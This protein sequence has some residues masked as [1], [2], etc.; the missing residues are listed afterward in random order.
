[1]ANKQQQQIQKVLSLY[2]DALSR[3]YCVPPVQF[4][5]VAYERKTVAGQSVLVLQSVPN[6]A[7]FSQSAST[8]PEEGWGSDHDEDISLTQ[9]VCGSSMHS[10]SGSR[11][12][13]LLSLDGTPAQRP[14]FD[15]APAERPVF[16]GTPAERPL[17][18]GTP[19]ERPH[20]DG[21]PAERPLFD[22]TPAERPLFDGTPAE[23]PLFDGT[24]AERPL[25]D[26]TP[27]ERPLFD[28]TPAERPSCGKEESR[29]GH[30][31]PGNTPSADPEA[32]PPSQRDRR[33]G[34]ADET[35]TSATASAT[36]FSR[37]ACGDQSACTCPGQTSPPSSDLSKGSCSAQ[38]DILC[39]SHPSQ[40]PSNKAFCVHAVLDNPQSRQE[41][42]CQIHSSD[43]AQARH[44][45]SSR[46]AQSCQT[47]SSCQEHSCLTDPSRLLQSCQTDSSA[48]IESSQTDSSGQVESSQT[49]SSGLLQSCQTDSSGQVESSQTDSSARVESSQTDSSGQIDSSQTDSSGQVESSQTGSSGQVESCQ[50]DTSGQVQSCQA[51]SSDQVQTCQ[52]GSSSQVESCNMGPPGQVQTCQTDSPSQSQSWPTDTSSHVVSR[53][54]DCRAST[55]TASGHSETETCCAQGDGGTK[56]CVK[57]PSSTSPSLPAGPHPA[58]T[59]P[60][61]RRPPVHRTPRQGQDGR[62]SG[63]YSKSG[64]NSPPVKNIV[65]TDKLSVHSINS[66][67]THPSPTVPKQKPYSLWTLQ[68]NRENS[69]KPSVVQS[70][71]IQDDFA[72][73]HVVHN[74]RELGRRHKET[75]FILSQYSF[76]DYL[77][78]STGKRK[79]VG[80]SHLKRPADLETGFR[81]GDFDVLVI[82]RRHGVLLGEVKSVGWNQ[83]IQSSADQ[84][85]DDIARRVERAVVQLHKSET[86]IR[87]LLDDVMPALVVRKTLFLP[88][89]STARLQR[90]LSTRQDLA[91]VGH[92]FLGCLLLG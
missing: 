91:K 28:G 15:G 68:S 60:D 26:G 66:P 75:M 74:L 63:S 12:V 47:L 16:D 55:V 61:S 30:D 32:G 14:L 89:V 39:H 35:S 81:R 71:N 19:A 36:P 1:M 88:Y 46:H 78:W 11:S 42:S 79:G 51:G 64:R 70:N 17:F 87:Y 59:D 73:N 7:D 29:S 65:Q 82:H 48:Q 62:H 56:A 84:A 49:D 6:C 9:L 57:V 4:N 21:T 37:S 45:D 5:H 20:F 33:P 18:D 31:G 85:D 54:H 43:Q 76:D 80:H 38:G 50:T 25:F 22:G 41:Q 23:R 72:Q 10:N 86:V 92:C 24:P 83:D 58:P 27:A 53:R 69:S 77:K 3:T 44:V 8:R 2:P 34:C 13:A 90:V 52:S 40:T 67:A